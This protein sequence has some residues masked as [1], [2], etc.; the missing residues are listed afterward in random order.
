MR[1]SSKHAGPAAEAVAPAGD[2]QQDK[3]DRIIEQAIMMFTEIGYERVRVS[4]ITDALDMGKGTFYLYFRNKKELL[5]A[6]FEHLGELVQA[7]DSRSQIRGGDFFTRIGPRT[8]TA[9]TYDW[10]PALMN[11]LRAAEL[12]PDA[13]FKGKAREVYEILAY[14]LKRDLEA[15]TQ[16]GRARDVDAELAAYGFIGLAENLWLRSRLDNRYAPEQVVTFMIDATTRWLASGTCAEEEVQPGLDAAARLIDRDRT[17]FDLH[18]L[19]ADGETYLTAALGQAQ[20]DLD[21]ARVSS[22]VIAETGEDCLANVTTVDGT[23]FRLRIDGSTVLSGSTP[24]AT[25]RIAMR[26]VSSLTR[27]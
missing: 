16:T 17:E 10:W 13:E 8:E 9:H 14:P 26:D 18:D 23:E 19:R 4:D 22:L 3:R 25:V 5:L 11:L 20:I 7:L 24:M 21:L 2:G 27:L 15:A 12:S 6:C 1:A